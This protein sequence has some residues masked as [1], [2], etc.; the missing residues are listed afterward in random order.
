M[1]VAMQG[2][3]SHWMVKP[4]QILWCAWLATRAANHHILGHDQ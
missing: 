1:S 4:Q 2:T 3:L